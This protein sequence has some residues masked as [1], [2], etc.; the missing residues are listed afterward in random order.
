L[1]ED[2]ALPN[3]SLDVSARAVTLLSRG[4]LTLNLSVA[5]LRH[6]IFAVMPLLFEIGIDFGCD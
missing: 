5:V 3:K 6:V 4:L 2:D 1:P